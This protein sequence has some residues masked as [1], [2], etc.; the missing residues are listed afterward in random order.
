MLC[1][2]AG[3]FIRLVFILMFPVVVLFIVLVLYLPLLY[4]THV[5]CRLVGRLIRGQCSFEYRVM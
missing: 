2:S 1:L 4:R 5:I 3:A